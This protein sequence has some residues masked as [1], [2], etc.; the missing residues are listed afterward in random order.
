MLQQRFSVEAYPSLYFLKDG[1]TRECFETRTLQKVLGL[2]R[3]SLCT[4][5][6]TVCTHS[7]IAVCVI[8]QIL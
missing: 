5:T 1:E 2:P 4:G 6:F 3:C 8:F 7:S